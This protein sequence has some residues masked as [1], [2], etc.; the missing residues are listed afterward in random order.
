VSAYGL[1][2][3]GSHERNNNVLLRGTEVALFGFRNT[4]KGK[5]SAMTCR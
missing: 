2:V 3:D 4:I 5:P 1:S